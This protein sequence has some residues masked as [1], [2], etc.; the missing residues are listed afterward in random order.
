MKI[1]QQE[2]GRTVCQS[3]CHKSL[4]DRVLKVGENR[5]VYSENTCH[6]V[7]VASSICKTLEARW[8]FQWGEKSTHKRGDGAK[9]G[10]HWGDTNSVQI[11]HAV[12]CSWKLDI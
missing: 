12:N 4:F 5:G 8:S 6:E 1:I 9:F 10:K 11:H 7:L 3:Q 2:R